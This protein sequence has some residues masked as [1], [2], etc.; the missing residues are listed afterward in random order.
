MILDDVIANVL[1]FGLVMLLYDA[2]FVII[3]SQ[4]G[5]TKHNLPRR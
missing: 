3:S 2:T 5:G 4:Q 1:S